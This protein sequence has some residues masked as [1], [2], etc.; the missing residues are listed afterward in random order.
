MLKLETA[1]FHS[2]LDCVSDPQSGFNLRVVK[3]LSLKASNVYDVIKPIHFCSQVIGLASFSIKKDSRQLYRGSVTLYNVVCL[4]ISTV[5]SLF[6]FV[7]LV[8]FNAVWILNRKYLSEF[9]ET[10]LVSVICFNIV[11]MVFIIWWLFFIK[12][13]LITLLQ[14]IHDVDEALDKLNV[15]INHCKHKKFLFVYVIALKIINFAGGVSTFLMSKITNFY[16]L[17]F[18][19]SLAD[20]IGNEYYSVFCSQA[21]F[22]LWAV[23]I[24]YQN[25]NQYLM[26]VYARKV[27]NEFSRK[28]V[29]DLKQVAR[30]HDKLVDL[31]QDLSFCYG[32]AVSLHKLEFYLIATFCFSTGHACR[33]RLFCFHDLLGLHSLFVL[34]SNKQREHELGGVADNISELVHVDFVC[35]WHVCDGTACEE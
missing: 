4:I 26:K 23:R 17:T 35:V 31:A 13:K 21:I 11:I 22:F 10:C 24:R 33:W 3:M 12:E 15:P 18:I 28:D 29:E 16:K 8:S 1:H 32:V 2:K 6:T 25:I 19:M 20:F 27:S 5:W 14:S 9:F 34:A 7:R 30:L